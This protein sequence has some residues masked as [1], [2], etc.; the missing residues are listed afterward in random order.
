MW[1]LSYETGSCAPLADVRYAADPLLRHVRRRPRAI[2]VVDMV[3]SVRLIGQDEEGVVCRWLNLVDRVVTQVLPRSGG[4]LVK[5]LGDGM[6][7]EFGD[8]RSAASA[9]ISIQQ[10][11]AQASP[12]LPADEQMFLRMGIEF[13]DVIVDHHDVYGRG[14]NLAARLATLAGPNEI[15]ISAQARDLLIPTLDAEIEDLGECHVKHIRQP[16]RAYRIGPA[17]PRPVVKCTALLGE[18]R[19]SIAIIPFVPCGQTISQD[20]LGEVLV[21]EII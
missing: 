3:E 4:R 17:G 14:V 7:L 11:S 8:I 13:G 9:A 15:V 2:L 16:V 1:G 20:L 21:E 10:E 19:P 6:L 18:L 12:G 5:S